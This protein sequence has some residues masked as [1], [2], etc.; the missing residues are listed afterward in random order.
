MNLKQL[1]KNRYRISQDQ[2]FDHESEPGKTAW[3]WRYQ[4]IRGRHGVLYPYSATQLAVTFTSNIVANRFEDKKWKV[5][6]DGD[7]ER[8]T[9]IPLEALDSVLEAIKPRKKRQISEFNRLKSI[10]RLKA[11]SFGKK[12]ALNASPG[13]SGALEQKI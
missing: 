12:T 3:Q 6:Q 11:Y 9:L 13:A 4:E 1:T 7:D 5:L 8:T 2:S 10:E